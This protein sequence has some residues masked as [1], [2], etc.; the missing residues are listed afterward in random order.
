MKKTNLQIIGT[1]NEKYPKSIV[2]KEKF[3]KLRK[4]TPIPNIFFLQ[5][6]VNVSVSIVSF[7]D[8]VVGIP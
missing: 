5:A 4:D 3:S 7:A 8:F 2:S 6:V 1:N